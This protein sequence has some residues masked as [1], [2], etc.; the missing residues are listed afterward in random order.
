M[1]SIYPEPERKENDADDLLETLKSKMLANMRGPKARRQTL[2]NKDLNMNTYDTIITIIDPPIETNNPNAL[3]KRFKNL[4]KADQSKI[5]RAL[6]ETYDKE[7]AKSSSKCVG[8]VMMKK[9]GIVNKRMISQQ[10]KTAKAKPRKT[11]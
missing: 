10:K 7:K 6:K 9:G 11:K 1:N 2:V 8:C 3:E 4:K 5:K